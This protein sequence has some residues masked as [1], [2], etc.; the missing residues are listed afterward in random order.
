L[1][2]VAKQRELFFIGKTRIHLDQVE[3]LGTFLELEVVLDESE[4]PAAGMAVAEELMRRLKVL[5]EQLISNSYFDLLDG[6]IE[7]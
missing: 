6:N 2:V 4:T 1:G 7:G 3:G 5:P